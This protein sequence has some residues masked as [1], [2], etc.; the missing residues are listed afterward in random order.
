[1]L[2]HKLSSLALGSLVVL[3]LGVACN[4][5]EDDTD[6]SPGG[7]AG[8]AGAS[9]G[10]NSRAGSSSTAGSGGS[11]NPAGGSNG[12]GTAGKAPAG[13]EG[14]ASLVTPGGA[15]GEGGA[16]DAGGAGGIGGDSAGAG[17]AG[18]G[19]EIA[20]CETVRAGLLGPIASVSTGLVEVTSDANAQLV[21]V[22]IDASAGGFAAAANNP[23]IY[24]SLAN[25]ARVDV[26]DAAADSSTAW[27]LAFK[28]D[29]IRANGGDSGP[30]N[31]QVAVLA[32]ADFDATT[33]AAATGATFGKDSFVDALTCEPVVDATGKPVTSFDGWYQYDAATNGLAPADRVYLVRGANGTSLYKLK[34]TGYY[35][36]VPTGTG[37]TVKKSAVYSL[38]Y[39]AL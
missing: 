28:R 26:T 22:V 14:G 29:N 9:A 35:V 5:D 6:D 27:D 16:A 25:K 39:Q 38:K 34:L 10:T 32:A 3:A 11:K 12:A 33:S 37:G 8:K 31:A 4:S 7:S 24:V 2:T 18:G 23:Y 1:M 36:D 21:T 30:G 20:S 19:A 17:G 13:G 15:A